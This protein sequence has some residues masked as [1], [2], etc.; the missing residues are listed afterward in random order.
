MGVRSL[1]GQ[2]LAALVPSPGG[3][4]PAPRTDPDSVERETPRQAEV[5]PDPQAERVRQALR[6]VND[7]LV[8]RRA[9]VRLRLDSESKRIVFMIMDENNEV[10]KQIPP[11]ELLKISNK[12]RELQGALFDQRA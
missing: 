11:E 8:S 4:T 1:S 10:I 7:D 12:F 2:E 6:E 3:R 9:G 5:K